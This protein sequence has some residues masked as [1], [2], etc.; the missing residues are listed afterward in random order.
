MLHPGMA[1]LIEPARE[2]RSGVYTARVS[3]PMSGA[4]ELSVTGFLFDGRR[5][6]RHIANATIGPAS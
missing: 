4:W 2:E 6:R 3:F 5:L 1:P